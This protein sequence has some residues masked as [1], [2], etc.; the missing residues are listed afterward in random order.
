VRQNGKHSPT[1][2]GKYTSTP[3]ENQAVALPPQL[4]IGDFSTFGT[5]YFEHARIQQLLSA[6]QAAGSQGALQHIPSIG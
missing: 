6:G 1:Q 5:K 4:H 3:V 2:E